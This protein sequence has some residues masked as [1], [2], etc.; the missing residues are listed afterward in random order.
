MYFFVSNFNIMQLIITIGMIS[1]FMDLQLTHLT[2]TFPNL[3]K[4][5]VPNLSTNLISVSKFY[6]KVPLETR[7]VLRKESIKENREKK[8]KEIFFRENKKNRFKLNKL[9][10]YVLFKLILFVSLYYIRAKKFKNM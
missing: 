8:W 10:L 2:T 3:R 5:H 4:D 9:I 1:E 6:S 7:K